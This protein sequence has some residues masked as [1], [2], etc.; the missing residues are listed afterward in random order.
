[1]FFETTLTRQRIESTKRKGYWPDRSLRDSVLVADQAKTA[2]IDDRKQLTYGELTDQAEALAFGLLAIGVRPRDV[3]QVQLP[4]WVEFIVATLALERIGAVIN[5]VA[6]IFRHHEVTIMNGLAKPKV[7]ICAR[8][9]RSFDYATMHVEIREELAFVEEIV[10]VGKPIPDTRSW[11]EV[12]ELGRSTSLCTEALD[13]LTPGP[14]DVIEVIFTSGTTGQPK[15][16]LHTTNTLA[17]GLSGIL[18]NLHH[19]SGEVVHMASTFGHQTGF[20]FGA[21]LPLV[22]GG[23][24][25]YQD[26]WDPGAFVGLIAEHGI[27]ASAGAAPFLADL[28]AVPGLDEADLSTFT[29][30]GCFGS[31]IPHSLLEEAGQRLPCAVMPGWGMSEISLMTTTA[32]SDSLD[33]RA[34]TDGAPIEGNEIRVVSDDGKPLDAGIEGDLQA[35]G[36]LEF[37]GYLQGR[38]FSEGFYTDDGWF[39]TGDRA[40]IDADGYVRITGRSKDLIIRGGENVPAKEIE[41]ILL[42]H[43]SVAAVAVVAMPHERLGEVGCAFVVAAAGDDAPTL[44]DLTDLL[45][46][47]KVTRQFW[48]EAMRVVEEFPMTASGKVQKYMLRSS[49]DS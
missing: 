21:R 5:P 36:V 2:L 8:E 6:P 14:D 43:P 46:K 38:D 7:I 20:L 24:G 42:R 33:K 18:P 4:N 41:D 13:L 30:F 11:D 27:T 1:M 35:R 48:P 31:A 15:G 22:V 45:E 28:L 25:I 40:V 26:I 3:V 9:F 32:E 49:L 37:V 16:V 44:S 19:G 10:V 47:Q 34:L 12:L 39:D 23:T 29:T 17:A